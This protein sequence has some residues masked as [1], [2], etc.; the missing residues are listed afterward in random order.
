MCLHAHGCA[1]MRTGACTRN[2]AL[3]PKKWCRRALRQSRGWLAATL[4]SL[5]QAPPLTARAVRRGHRDGQR[6]DGLLRHP[7]DPA[8][9]GLA[10]HTA[11]RRPRR[12][13]VGPHPGACP[14]GAAL[15]NH[16]CSVSHT[17]PVT[18]IRGSARVVDRQGGG[19]EETPIPTSPAMLGRARQRWN[20]SVLTIFHLCNCAA[21]WQLV[22]DMGNGSPW[23]GK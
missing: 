4:P 19:Q 23:I 5:S 16:S 8:L 21:A 10:A 7:H 18:V 11:R 15:R 3:C 14:A 13:R 17:V 12:P 1:Q 20:P 9:P 6:E 22:G 2:T